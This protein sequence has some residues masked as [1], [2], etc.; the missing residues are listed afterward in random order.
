MLEPP[1]TDERS[2]HLKL[3]ESEICGMHLPF[4]TKQCN[5]W[6]LVLKTNG[7]EEVS[8]HHGRHV[9]LIKTD[10]KSVGEGTLKR[11]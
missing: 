3:S 8:S 6:C 4:T 9:W 7:A 11:F 10:V 1:E 5:R 2:K